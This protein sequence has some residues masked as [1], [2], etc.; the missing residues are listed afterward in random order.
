MYQST[1]GLRYHLKVVHK[2]PSP[3]PVV[4][5][6]KPAN[7]LECLDPLL[8][9]PARKAAAVASE[10]LKKLAVKVEESPAGKGERLVSSEERSGVDY[11]ALKHELVA[12]GVLKCP[13]EVRSC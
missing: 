3:L 11:V 2:T 6:S 5:D 13:Y 1:A 7:L 8:P 10:R 12:N 4:E 9:L